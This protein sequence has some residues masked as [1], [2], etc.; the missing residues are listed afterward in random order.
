MLTNRKIL[1]VEDDEDL[2]MIFSGQL[3]ELNSSVV[4]AHSGNEAIKL[5]ENGLEVD[6]IVSDYS[7]TDGDGIVVLEYVAR[8]NL[9]V[10]FVFFTNN[11]DPAIPVKYDKFLGT[12]HKFNFNRLVEVIRFS[13]PA[14]N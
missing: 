5:L 1:L 8:N 11:P 12:I 6:F 4:I 2:R 9:S 10:P 14:S 13:F 3:K 7:M